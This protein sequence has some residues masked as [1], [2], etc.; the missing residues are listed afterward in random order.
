MMSSSKKKVFVVLFTGLI[1]ILSIYFNLYFV[2]SNS[3]DDFL[4]ILSGKLNISTIVNIADNTAK[5]YYEG[6]LKEKEEI[7]TPA[8]KGFFIELYG[9]TQK[10]LDTDIIVSTDPEQS[11]FKT[12]D[13]R[14]ILESLN[15][16]YTYSEQMQSMKAFSEW[17]DTKEIDFL[18]AQAPTKEITAEEYPLGMIN[19]NVNDCIV[20]CLRENEIPFI[21]FRKNEKLSKNASEWHYRTDHHWTT[22]TALISSQYL[23]QELNRIYGYNLNDNILNLNNFTQELHKNVFLGSIGKKIGSSFA[24]RD[25]FEIYLPNASTLFYF[26]ITHSNDAKETREGSFEETFIFREHLQRDYYK[27]NPFVSYLGNDYHM[28]KIENK[29]PVSDKRF[30]VIKDSYANA[31]VPYLAMVAKEIIMIDPRLYHSSI[32]DYIEDYNP[33]AVILIYNPGAYL[34]ET[35]F[36]FGLF[37]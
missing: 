37:D 17:L 29:M 36:N 8:R 27:K 28:V 9:L 21:D 10:I 34:E 7:T 23:V 32:K 4:G 30:L 15:K 35:F 24:G 31:L 2:F 16:V 33:D 5:G 26:E 19:K 18:M 1:F 3:V 22:E 11:L 13:G 20:E 6:L 14:L 25:D 12:K